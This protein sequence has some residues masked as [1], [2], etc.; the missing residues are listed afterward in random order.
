MLRATESY[1]SHHPNVLYPEILSYVGDLASQVLK[2]NIGPDGYT[3]PAGKTPQKDGP[4][5]CLYPHQ[6]LW[7][8]AFIAAWT[9]D[10]PQGVKDIQLLLKGQREDGFIGHIRYDRTAKDYFPPPDIYHQ[11]GLPVDGEVTSKITQPPNLT[12]GV[13]EL[14]K[15]LPEAEKRVF[16]K[17][18]FP[19]V[20]KFHQYIY[21]NRVVDNSGLMVTIHPWEAGD[22]NS[23]KWDA[24]YDNFFSHPEVIKELGKTKDDNEMSVKMYKN[25]LNWLRDDIKIPYERLDLKL[26]DPSQ[27]PINPDYDKYL[28]LIKLYNKLGWNDKEIIE[29]SPFRVCDPM[30]NA[31]LLRS[32]QALL[33]M[34]QFLDIPQAEIKKIKSWKKMTK[35]GVESLWDEQDGLYYAK[36]L[37]TN[38]LLKVD[39]SSSYM[40]LFSHQIDE[41]RV[42]RLVE[43]LS[44]HQNDLSFLYMVPSTSAHDAKF[45]DQRY[46]RGPVWPVINKLIAEGLEFYGFKEM[47]KIIRESSLL[48]VMNSLKHQGGFF[49]YYN[50]INGDP[51]G[52]PS[53]S[54]TAAATLLLTDNEF[55]KDKVL[56]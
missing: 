46:W 3:Y 31:V 27:R 50:P 54:W 11:D 9:K 37:E 20:M 29:N 24:I 7:D 10:L 52:S 1:G 51:L 32:D 25:V 40:P 38:N 23:P 12:Y 21:E 28:F 26:I 48:L 30:T 13:W 56:L 35:A 6:W 14:A 33:K 19:K 49:E 36:D 16:L 4:P 8:T 43:K 17:E 5:K 55:W 44:F 34:A 53:Q 39:T 47:A 15:K 2:N 18:V 41:N 45:D 42:A 22:D